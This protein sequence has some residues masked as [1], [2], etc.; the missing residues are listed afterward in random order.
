MVAA[1]PDDVE[2]IEMGEPP[3]PVAIIEEFML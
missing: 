3:V 2:F 1:V